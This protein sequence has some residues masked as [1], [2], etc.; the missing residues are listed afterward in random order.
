MPSNAEVMLHLV[1]GQDSSALTENTYFSVM[2]INVVLLNHSMYF[3]RSAS[4]HSTLTNIGTDYSQLY[5][6]CN[7]SV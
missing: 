7:S 1:S 4:V 2:M 5:F 6:L 3:H